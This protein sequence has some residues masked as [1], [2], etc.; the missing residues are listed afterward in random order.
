MRCFFDPFGNVG[1]VAYRTATKSPFFGPGDWDSDHYISLFPPLALAFEAAYRADPTLE[2]RVVDWHDNGYSSPSY[3]KTAE[4]AGIDWHERPQFTG[5]QAVYE[6]LMG[7]TDQ[8]PAVL[9]YPF[10]MATDILLDP[11][12]VFQAAAKGGAVARELGIAMRTADDATLGGRVI[13][14]ILEGTGAAGEGVARLPDLPVEGLVKG[15]G[16]KIGR[17]HV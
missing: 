17:A 8:M 7:L 4:A 10:R 11:L 14:G 15:G 6:G 13:G 5:D 9:K 16:L 12:G 3:I 2:A 1:A